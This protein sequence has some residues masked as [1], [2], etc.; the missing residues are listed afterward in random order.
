MDKLPI[1]VI[2]PTKNN[3][4]TLKQCLDSI[5]Q[6]NPAEILIIDGLSHDN[7]IE[8]AQKYT[9]KIYSDEGRGP[10]A[11]HQLGVLHANQEY[12]AYIDAD[13]VMPENTLLKLLSEL[14]LSN[15]VGMQAKIIAASKESY[16]ERGADFNITAFQNSK[17]GFGISAAVLKRDIILKYGFDEFIKPAGDDY[18]LYLRLQMDG[19]NVGIS[20]N[21]VYH[22]HKANFNTVVKINLRYAKAYPRFILKYG[23]FN[24][25]FYPPLTRLYWT[26][27]CVIKGK[28]NFIP[29]FVVLGLAETLGMI[30]GFFDIPFEYIRKL[31]RK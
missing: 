30:K 1:S 8:I 15:F 2:I 29:Y 3:G 12:I 11:A 4:N 24:A 27:L 19:N 22:Y 13:I 21:E 31:K 23:L 28:P 25:H 18:D 14:R 10:S 9:N 6:N 16:W 7:T 20:N 5:I 17:Y 26:I